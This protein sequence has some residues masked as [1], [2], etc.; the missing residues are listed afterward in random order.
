MSLCCSLFPLCC[1]DVIVVFIVLRRFHC[2]V[3]CFRCV[4]EILW[5]FSLCCEDSVVLRLV[6]VVLRR[7]RCVVHYR[8]TID[9]SL[10]GIICMY[11]VNNLTDS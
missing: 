9:I 5:L 2:V 3:A 8:D 7:F 6:S 11:K 4:V 1:G 10:R